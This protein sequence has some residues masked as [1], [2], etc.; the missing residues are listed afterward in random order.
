MTEGGG[1]C[2]LAATSIPDKLHTVGKPAPGHDIRLIDE[3][4]NEVAS[5]RDRRSRRPLGRDDDRL[6]R[7]P[8]E[9]TDGDLA[10]RP[11]ATASSAT[12]MSA[13]STRTA[14]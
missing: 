2:I 10:R 4:G 1:T 12:A 6:S 14:S 8:G 11:R 13:A 5:R 9:A 3:D 7:P